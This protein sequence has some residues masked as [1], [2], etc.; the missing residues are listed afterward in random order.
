MSSKRLIKKN[1]E[2]LRD[3]HE[4]YGELLAVRRFDKKAQKEFSRLSGDFNPIHLEPIF[5]RRTIAGECIVHGVHMLMW[6]LDELVRKCNLQI[7][8][9]T[10]SFLKPAL[11]DI[12][13]LLYWNS[14]AK[15]IYIS[16]GVELLVTVSLQ[17]CKV[18]TASKVNLALG[19]KLLRPKDSKIAEL[20][21]NK[22]HTFSYT[23]N[24]N[25]AK[26]LFPNFIKEYGIGYTVE[27]A[28]T[29]EIVGMRSPGLH[30]LFVGLKG[31]LNG[32][33]D[34]PYYEI[35]SLDPRFGMLKID[36][37]GAISKYEITALYRQQPKATPKVQDLS[38]L[39]RQKE[40]SKVKALIIGGSRGI[41]SLTAKLLAAGGADL[42]ITYSI[43][44]SDAEDLRDEILDYGA[45]CS[46]R[47][48]SIGENYKFP[49][50]KFNQ[51]YYFATP[52]IKAEKTE[53]IDSLLVRNYESIYID[54][55]K[56]ILSMLEKTKNPINVFYP[57][58]KFIEEDNNLYKSYIAAK[59]E[60]EILCAQYNKKNKNIYIKYP[61]LPRLE[62]DQ[63]VG[64]MVEDE[65]ANA[66]E[67]MLPHIRSM[68]IW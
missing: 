26:K 6:A 62:T 16:S 65:F 56:N 60:G 15:K 13:I 42:C 54:G 31:N 1:G 5:S 24:A 39:V 52:K 28:A 64:I 18:S 2:K 29:S 46:L 9:F 22:P 33:V 3:K 45:S 51:I 32:G 38:K 66:V 36:A 48:L 14:E 20:D 17:I 7:N 35:I 23:G 49:R 50:G 59:N 27:L 34:W 37:L 47:K 67:V 43:M 10:C 4:K 40:F 11:L 57:S 44:K 53:K 12:D 58:T 8:Y 41:G 68:N 30:S 63:T 25:V 19:R 21:G 55:F 61:R